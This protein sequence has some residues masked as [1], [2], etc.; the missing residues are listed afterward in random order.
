MEEDDLSFLNLI[1]M[2]GTVASQRIDS[3]HSAPPGQRVDLVPRARETINMLIGLKKRTAGR[4]NE[5]EERV[6]ETMLKEL[7]ARYVKGLK[8]LQTP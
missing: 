5:Q 6:L 4:L 8:L 2:I 7:Q 1:L 3:L